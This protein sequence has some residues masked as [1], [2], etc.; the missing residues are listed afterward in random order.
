MT[1]SRASRC[2]TYREGAE[3]PLFHG[4]TYI[5]HYRQPHGRSQPTMFH[6]CKDTSTALF[7]RGLLFEALGKPYR[8]LP[9]LDRRRLVPRLSWCANCLLGVYP[10][11]RPT[12]CSTPWKFVVV[13][14]RKG[15]RQSRRPGAD[16]SMA[17]AI[18]RFSEDEPRRWEVCL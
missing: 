18:E 16:R 5:S 11:P 7:C 3:I 15:T 2:N 6:A 14:G 8:L 1:Q 13:V 17:E 4:S 9:L 12:S 10:L